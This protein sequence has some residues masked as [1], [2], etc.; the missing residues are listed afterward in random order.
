MAEEFAKHMLNSRDVYPINMRY[1]LCFDEHGFL[2]VPSF[3]DNTYISA[4]VGKMSTGIVSDVKQM[5]KFASSFK[6]STASD[7]PFEKINYKEKDL[8]CAAG[9]RTRKVIHFPGLSPEECPS[10]I[11]I[12]KVFGLGHGQDFKA[13]HVDYGIVIFSVGKKNCSKEEEDQFE[14]STNMMIS[15]YL[16][17][18]QFV[19]FID[20][21]LRKADPKLQWKEGQPLADCHDAVLKLDSDI[22]TLAALNHDDNVK[23]F[24]DRNVQ[25]SKT[26]AGFTEV[27]SSNDAQQSDKNMKRNQK[28]STCV[29][30]NMLLKQT[31]TDILKRCQNEGKLKLSE[32][33]KNAFIDC[34]ASNNLIDDKSYS[35][36]KV[37]QDGYVQ[38]ESQVAARLSR[39]KSTGLYVICVKW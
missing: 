13:C 12:L 15:Q 36:R 26:V 5:K 34:I 30:D 24:Q 6:H 19:P 20:D 18:N 38:E 32:K 8:N 7:N 23:K 31:I 39:I 27:G 28:R 2:F 16:I 22:V 11:L 37:I 1:L 33:R 29:S 21:D 25:V 35:S 9:N 3:D 14:F 17:Q 4:D 10:R